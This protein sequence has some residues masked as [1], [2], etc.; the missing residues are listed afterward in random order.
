MV[1][2]DGPG[3]P[4]AI[5]EDIFEPFVS[6]REAGTGLGLALAGRIVAG[7]GGWIAMSSAPGRTAVK[8]SLPMAPK[9]APEG[10]N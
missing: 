2:D 9:T 8:V 4:P 6:G 1:E 7:L 10:E 3:V 5:A